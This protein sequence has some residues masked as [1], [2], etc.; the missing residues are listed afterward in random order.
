MTRQYHQMNLPA[1]S[2]YMVKVIT[3]DGGFYYTDDIDKPEP[4]V[5]FCKIPYRS[6]VGYGQPCNYCGYCRKGEET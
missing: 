4:A 6:G 2:N 5:L 1:D 3:P